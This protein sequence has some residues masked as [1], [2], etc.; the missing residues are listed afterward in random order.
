MQFPPPSELTSHQEPALLVEKLLAVAPDGSWAESRLSN[1]EGLDLLQLIEGSAQT[2][3]ILMGVTLRAAGGLRAKGMLVG[4]T[5]AVQCAG[6]PANEVVE[7]RVALSYQF[8]PFSLFSATVTCAG[9][10]AATLE[11]KTMAHSS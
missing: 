11:L 6:I 7:V 8:P 9:M 5:N 10:P 1:P 4:V 2:V 3:A